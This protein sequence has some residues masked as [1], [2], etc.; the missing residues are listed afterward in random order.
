MMD[1][2]I[3]ATRYVVSDQYFLSSMAATTSIGI[4][5][6]AII[7]N[8]DLRDLKK[9]IVSILAYVTVLSMAISTRVVP[10][11]DE[12]HDAMTKGQPF[13]GIV[14]ILLVTAFYGFGMLLG[15]LLV[16]FAHKK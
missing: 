9:G 5:I 8:G 3:A 15:V 2:L 1:Y 14:T 6:G 16:K 10:Q 13:A 7:Y 4:F 11:L 12:L